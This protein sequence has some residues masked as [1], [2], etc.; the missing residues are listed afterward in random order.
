VGGGREREVKVPYLFTRPNNVCDQKTLRGLPYKSIIL[1][2]KYYY[3]I[4]ISPKLYGKQMFSIIALSLLSPLLDGSTFSDTGAPI[5]IKQSAPLPVQ[6][7][8]ALVQGYFL[9]FVE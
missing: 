2:P 4:Q 3:I 5:L 1:F 7:R 6:E 9:N 8:P